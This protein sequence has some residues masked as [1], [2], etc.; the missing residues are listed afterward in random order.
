MDVHG[1]SLKGGLEET[2]TTPGFPSRIIL[3]TMTDREIALYIG[4]RWL[5]SE[6]KVA[7][8]EALLSEHLP[9]WKERLRKIPAPSGLTPQQHLVVLQN[10]IDEDKSDDSE[11]RILHQV[12]FES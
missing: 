1:L 7:A 6:A 4:E 12:L 10:A 2:S 5:N 8:L 11:I 3:S 9:D